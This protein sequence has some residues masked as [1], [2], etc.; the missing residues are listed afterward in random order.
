MKKYGKIYHF[1]G[2]EV[3]NVPNLMDPTIRNPKISKINKCITGLEGKLTSPDDYMIQRTSEGLYKINVDSS[4]VYCSDIDPT[5]WMQS[6]RWRT[7]VS[8]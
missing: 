5:P 4:M 2:G 8:M 6:E 1:F 3:D 7:I